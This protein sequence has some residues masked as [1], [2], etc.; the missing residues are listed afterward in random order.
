MHEPIA[1]S[2]RRT[3]G[4]LVDVVDGFHFTESVFVVDD[5]RIAFYDERKHESHNYHLHTDRTNAETASPAAVAAR[6]PITVSSGALTVKKNAV[7]N[8]KKTEKSRSSRKNPAQV[9]SVPMGRGV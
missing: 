8:K 3:V 1:Q 9:T 5:F 4:A 2:R 7:S 6:G